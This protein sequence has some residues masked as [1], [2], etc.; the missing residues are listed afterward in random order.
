MYENNCGKVKFTLYAFQ[1]LTG[2]INIWFILRVCTQSMKGAIKISSFNI[3]FVA[4]FQ[5]FM[6]CFFM[7]YTQDK[8]GLKLVTN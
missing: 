3:Q 7:T 8:S 4:N 1:H 2:D 6:Y 5:I